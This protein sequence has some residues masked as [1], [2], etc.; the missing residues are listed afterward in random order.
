MTNEQILSAYNDAVGIIG[1]MSVLL[2]I[3]IGSAC[4]LKGKLDERGPK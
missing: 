3:A 2:F 4:Y 1:F